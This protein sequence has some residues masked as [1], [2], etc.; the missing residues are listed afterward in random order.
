MLGSKN[1][2]SWIASNNLGSCFARGYECWSL[3]LVELQLIQA[4]TFR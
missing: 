2:G 1:L 3:E 4:K